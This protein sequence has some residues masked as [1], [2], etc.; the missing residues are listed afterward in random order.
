MKVLFVGEGPHDIGRT[1]YG[2][3]FTPA[4]GIVSTLCKRISPNISNESASISLRRLTAYSPSKKAGLDHKLRI[5]TELAKRRGFGGTIAVV[6]D[7]N[8]KHGRLEQL[9][10]G[11]RSCL[12]DDPNHRIAVGVAVKS[13]EAWVLA[14]PKALAQCLG[15]SVGEVEQKYR[16]GNVEQFHDQ[17]GKPEYHSKKLLEDIARMDHKEDCTEWRVDV[18]ALADVAT[19]ERHCPSGFKPFADDVRRHFCSPAS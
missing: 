14:D 7:D 12:N 1:E 10:D 16:P 8:G 18:V 15:K 13:I 9:K 4:D 19:V 11:Q 2:T 3:E 5:A 17:S 6:D